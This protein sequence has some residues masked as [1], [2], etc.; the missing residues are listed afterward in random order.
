MFGI[1]IV[2]ISLYIPLE[3]VM[4]LVVWRNTSDLIFN[5]R[6]KTALILGESELQVI[7]K[8]QKEELAKKVKPVKR[9]GI[10]L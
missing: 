3:I 7:I 5:I 10:T 8:E 6:L 2:A 9:E 1:R 4:L